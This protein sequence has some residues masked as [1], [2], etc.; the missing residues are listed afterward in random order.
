M[1]INVQHFVAQE[2]KYWQELESFM[3]RLDLNQTEFSI[4]DIE[5]FHYLYERTSADLGKL[6]TYA[7]DP[8]LR[9]YLEKLVSRAY[10]EI[11]E[12]REKGTRLRFLSWLTVEFPGAFRRHHGA[13]IMACMLTLVG[14]LL[15]GG[16]VAFDGDVKQI[17]LPFDHL[18]G[19][20]TERVAKEESVTTDRLEGH[21]STFSAELMVN[22][23]RVSIMA[24]AL[25]ISWGIGTIIVLFY[26]GVILGAVIVDYMLNGQTRFLLGWLLPHGSVEI[27][28]ILIA[29]QAGLTLAHTLIGK[30]SPLTLKER[31]RHTGRDLVTLIG[32]VAIML[33]WAGIVE[34]FFSQYHEPYLPYTIKIIFGSISLIILFVFLYR[35]GL[36]SNLEA[37]KGCQK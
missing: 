19:S 10:G 11:H 36:S 18:H 14:C 17:L 22:N 6:T 31:F 2:E 13:F 34:A 28:A 30:G 37:E 23:I 1:I 25:G 21:K 20:P 27:P 26:N 33:V 29:G 8:E 3:N 35:S 15:G 7:W 5:R 12:T 32:G 16:A 4:Q 24:M 9:M